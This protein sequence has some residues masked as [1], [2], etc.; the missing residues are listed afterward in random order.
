MRP[1]VI[2]PLPHSKSRL[3]L[4]L[5]LL[6]LALAPVVAHAS[7]ITSPV[8]TTPVTYSVAM[9]GTPFAGN[10]TFELNSTP[11]NAQQETFS[12]ASLLGLTI[13]IDGQTLTLSQDPGAQIIFQN[14]LLWD[15]GYT[16]TVNAGTLND[17]KIA[18]TNSSAFVLDYG[19]NL[20]KQENGTYGP[21]TQV[22]A[23]P[24]P[25]SL[26]LLGTGLMG[27]AGAFYRR[28]IAGR[29]S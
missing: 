27:V 2:S 17:L 12:G 13:S 29:A 7:P 3:K 19:N 9:N 18:S 15:I 1:L 21:L 6:S 11:T 22:P 10:I 14:G 23:T 24:E 8:A 26:V 5:T 28:R 16:G 25:D 20:T 4:A